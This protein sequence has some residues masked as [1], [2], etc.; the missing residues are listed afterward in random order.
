MDPHFNTQNDFVMTYAVP[1]IE[2][3]GKQI[4][5]ISAVIFA[6]DMAETMQKITIGKSSHPFIVNSKTGK[7]VAHADDEI[8]KQDQ[9]IEDISSKG[10]LEF[11]DRAKS[12]ESASVIYYDEAQKMKMAAAF[13][14]IENTD[15]AVVLCAPYADFFSGIHKVFIALLFIG[16]ISLIVSAVVVLLAVRAVIKPLGALSAAIDDVAT[17]EADLTKRLT[18]RNDDEIGKLV[19]GFNAFSGKLQTIIGD[20]KQ[21][22]TEL[23]TAGSDMSAAAE[24]TSNAITEITANISSIQNQIENQGESVNQAAGAVNQI[25]GNIESLEKMIESQGN[26]V[27]EASSA[28]EEMIGNISSV[29]AS[30]DKM[31]ESFETLRSNS[32]DGFKKQQSV[33]DKVKE[34]EEQSKMLQEANS[35]ISAIASQT[36]LLA[37]NAAIEAAHAGDAGAGFAVVADEIRKLSETSNKQS[38]TIGEQLKNIKNSINAVVS[39]SGEASATF[40]RVGEMLGETDAL[41]MQIKSAMQEQNEGSAQITSALQ[42]MNDSTLEVRSAGAEMREGNKM[43]LSE[44]QQL[45]NASSQMR[46]SMEEMDV[47]ARKISETGAAL[48][49]ISSQVQTSISKIGSQ[50][51][52]FK[53]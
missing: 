2:P 13:C 50:V 39:S 33:N 25:A 45:Q 5:E 9:K 15:W 7:I 26:S 29:N 19:K 10:F 14:P 28:V 52:Q 23:V 27:D 24:D 1:I 4:A 44:M 6:V 51:D 35:A 40:A 41:V 49:E 21:S 20:V 3:S 48:G 22:K 43:I 38:K 8:M 34:I 11:A 31:A 12:G 36:N 37:M 47:S 30:V 42:R 18:A 17:G 16:A 32:Q 46:Q 53:V